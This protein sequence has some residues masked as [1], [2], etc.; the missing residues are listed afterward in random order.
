M[1]PRLAAFRAKWRAYRADGTVDIIRCQQGRDAL[2][3]KVRADVLVALEREPTRLYR[4]AAPR[5]LYQTTDLRS[6]EER[7]TAEDVR[8][9]TDRDFARS[10]L[11]K[12][13]AIALAWLE[14]DFGGMSV[15]HRG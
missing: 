4:C 6:I 14:K 13:V 7:V 15:A 5:R 8:A 1:T 12:R 11:T 9:W 2:I 10:G 3:R